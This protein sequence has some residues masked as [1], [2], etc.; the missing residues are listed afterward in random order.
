[1]LHGCLV[2]NLHKFVRKLNNFGFRK[3]FF[4]F[5]CAMSLHKFLITAFLFQGCLD[6][7][8]Y[9]YR[10]HY[11]ILLCAGLVLALV[12]FFVLLSIVV[13]CTKIKQNKMTHRI[14]PVKFFDDEQASS[15]RSDSIHKNIR[16]SQVFQEDFVS[17]T[18][19][20]RESYV[21]PN[22]RKTRQQSANFSDRGHRNHRLT[23][24]GYLI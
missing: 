10:E 11:I 24:N 13:S 9:W 20:L 19:E 21:Q 6:K 16:A 5:P 22:Y 3:L 17:V 14:T 23:N 12:E 7:I 8:E 18:P 1:M 2:I 15:S 4:D